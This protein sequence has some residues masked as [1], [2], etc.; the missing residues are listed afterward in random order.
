MTHRRT[1]ATTA[2]ALLA[3]LV[4]LAACNKAAAPAPAAPAERIAT[5]N[6]KA[7]PKSEFDL[8]VTSLTRQSGHEVTP[9]QRQ[10]MLDQFINLHLAA[11]EAEKAGADKEQKVADQL[12]LARVQVLADEA[13]SRIG[14]LIPVTPVPLACA[15]IQSFDADFISRSQLLARMAEMREVLLEL[16]AR[17]LRGDRDIGETF[18]RAYRMLR[19]RRVLSHHGDGYA[20]LARGRPLVSYYANSIAHLLGPFAAGLRERD[21]LRAGLDL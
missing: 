3:P 19:M 6:G 16:N 17:V 11:E 18:D 5:V 7:L 14:E 15:A 12:A 8:Y 9:E 4:L 1:P 13:M 2:L 20:V 21:A 10:Q